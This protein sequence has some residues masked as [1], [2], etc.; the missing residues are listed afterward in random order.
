M[1]IMQL[2]AWGGRLE[3][4]IHKLMEDERPDIVCLQ[5]AIDYKG[6][7]YSLLGTLDALQKKVPYKYRYYSPGIRF[8]LMRKHAE[9]GNCILSQYPILKKSTHWTNL[10]FIDDFDFAEHDY[11]ARNFQH[12]ALKTKNNKSL[13]IL[14]H[15][16]HHIPSHKNGD[17]QTL[18]QMKMIGEYVD[19]L[20]G[21]VVLAGDFNLSPKSK[22]IEQLNKRLINLSTKYKLK[23]T[24]TPLTHKNEV[25]DYIF[26]SKDIKVKN[27]YASSEIVSDHMALVLDFD[28]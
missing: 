21:P 12:C 4:N 5:E 20:E 26:V 28:I 7:I 6:E 19:N 24:R 11:N 10:E 2:N 1:K 22:S 15:H 23:T 16:G 17:A 13:H 8:R 25:C 18:R 3:S 14:N 27:F 9:W